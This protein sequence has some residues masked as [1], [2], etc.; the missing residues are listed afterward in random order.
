[1]DREPELEKLAASLY[2]GK[3]PY[4][5]FGHVER[6]LSAGEKIMANCREHGITVDEQT[7]YYAI[8][9]HDAAFHE[10]HI[11]LGHPSKEAYKDVLARQ[12]LQDY[13]C[14]L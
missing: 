7:I 2:D 6:V 1:M 4:H 8:L 10:N 14:L 5:N 3:L 12:H 11:E 13:G 9:F